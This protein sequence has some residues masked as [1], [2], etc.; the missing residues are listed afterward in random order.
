VTADKDFMQLISAKTKMY[1]PGRQGTDVEIVDTAKAALRPYSPKRALNI[2]LGVII[3]LVVGIGL[4]FFIEYLDTSVKTI[5]DVERALGA[6]VL[7]VIPQNVGIL[8][9][10]LE[11]RW[12]AGIGLDNVDVEAASMRGIVVMNTPG[13]NTVTTAEH[14]MAMIFSACSCS[15]SRLCL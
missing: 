14:T 12:R 3:G 7:G 13:G 1:K 11:R 15:A 8:P 4:A 10:A 5:D 9:Q 6:P 2:T